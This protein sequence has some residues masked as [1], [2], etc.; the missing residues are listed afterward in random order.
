[1]Q[2]VVDVICPDSLVD[3][4]GPVTHPIDLTVTKEEDLHRIVIK[5][6]Y[7][8]FDQPTS[9]HGLACWF[10]VDFATTG[11]AKKGTSHG[12]GGAHS[13]SRV[14]PVPKTLT[15]APGSP[16]THW[17]QLRCCLRDTLRVMPGQY[18]EGEMI[19]RANAKQSYDVDV[20][21]VVVDPSGFWVG[22][23]CKGTFD[24]K[25]PY[26]RQLLNFPPKTQ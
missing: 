12:V 10:D 6:R 5:L 11:A 24:L 17:C 15:T 2:V 9:V 19:L 3:C 4:S 14:P 20:S 18:I 23:P 8:N 1:M 21:L 7:D 25:N 22:A 16:T 13:F 26:Y